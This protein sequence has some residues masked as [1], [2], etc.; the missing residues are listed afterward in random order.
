MG[1]RPNIVSI[2]NFEII[3]VMAIHDPPPAERRSGASLERGERQR[4]SHAASGKNKNL[5]Q[6]Q[7]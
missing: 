6:I 2:A 1:M 5:A 4:P 7:L 3:V